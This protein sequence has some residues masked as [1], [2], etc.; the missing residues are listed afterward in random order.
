LTLTQQQ[1]ST[2][3]TL[4]SNSLNTGD[5]GAFSQRLAPALRQSLTATAFQD[6]ASTS[7]AITRLELQAPPQIDGEWA[8][9]RVKVFS[10]G[11]ELGT[12]R[13]VFHHEDGSW[14]LFGTEQP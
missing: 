4:L 10:T 5:Y 7:A 11:Q 12:Y 2:Q 9:T 6:L 1:V 8:E 14:Y 13:A 3:V